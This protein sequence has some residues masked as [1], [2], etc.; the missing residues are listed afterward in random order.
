MAYLLRRPGP[1][2]AVDCRQ[3]PFLLAT[4]PALLHT[5]LV[6]GVLGRLFCGT[7]SVLC[8]DLQFLTESNAA[9]FALRRPFSEQ[10]VFGRRC[11]RVM[12]RQAGLLF[13]A[14]HPPTPPRRGLAFLLPLSPCSAGFVGRGVRVLHATGS[15]VGSA[16]LRRT[17]G[18]RGLAKVRGVV[19]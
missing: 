18:T 17:F 4:H 11:R 12:M 14:C 3:P 5:A 8:C 9:T 15:G 7:R 2:D 6:V 10:D 1:L 19:V 13:S 16:S